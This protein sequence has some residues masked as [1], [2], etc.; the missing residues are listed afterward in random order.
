MIA[1][2]LR[3][4]FANNIDDFPCKYCKNELYKQKVDA[5]NA[6]LLFAQRLYRETGENMKHSYTQSEE[7][8]EM[9]QARLN[10][11]NLSEVKET[12]GI[13]SVRRRRVITSK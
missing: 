13:R 1:D 2:L 8:P 10:A 3:V 11:K 4:R 12:H 5:F 9:V 6:W 7:L